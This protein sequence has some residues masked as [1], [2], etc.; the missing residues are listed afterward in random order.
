MCVHILKQLRNKFYGKSWRGIM[1][2]YTTNGYRIWNPARR[3]EVAA[4][5]VIFLDDKVRMGS[6][7]VKEDSSEDMSHNNHQNVEQFSESAEKE[8]TQ[9]TLSNTISDAL[10]CSTEFDE[11]NRTNHEAMWYHHG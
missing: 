8:N 11:Y 3:E 4:R 7:P 9:S 10:E 1:I 2:G 5:D 6:G